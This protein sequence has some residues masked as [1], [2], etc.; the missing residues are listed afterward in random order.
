MCHFLVV[1]TETLPDSPTGKESACDAGDLGSIPGPGR[2][3]G[4]G[5][6]CPLQCSRPS[7]VAYLV[8]NLSAV[9]ET[10]AQ[11]LGWEDPLE[12]GKATYSSILTWRIPWMV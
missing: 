6:G 3:T 11:S 5:M 9:W 2:S 7:L 8:K 4:E 1:F 10:W 12:K